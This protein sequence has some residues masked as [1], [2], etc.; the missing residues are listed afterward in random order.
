PPSGAGFPQLTKTGASPPAAANGGN[1][2]PSGAPARS[3]AVSVFPKALPMDGTADGGGVIYSLSSD[4]AAIKA[5][6]L[7]TVPLAI[8]AN[9]G[10]CVSIT[11]ENDT[12]TRAGFSLGKLPFDPQ[13]SFGAAVGFD[14]DSSVAPGQSFTYKFWADRELGTNLFMN[15]ANESSIIHGAF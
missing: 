6:T 5:G 2:C 13:G 1:P 7:P 8:R 10:D 15:W 14:P 11:L 3:Y 9:A 12:A 4:E